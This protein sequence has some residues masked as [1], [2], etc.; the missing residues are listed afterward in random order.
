MKTLKQ[1]ENDPRVYQVEKNP[2][3]SPEIA[4]DYP[5]WHPSKY[6]L[7]LND[8]WR[9][10]DNSHVNGADTVTELSKLLKEVEAEVIK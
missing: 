10:N 7:H 3:W 9:F 1:I 4:K 8:G 5:D 6:I 2:D